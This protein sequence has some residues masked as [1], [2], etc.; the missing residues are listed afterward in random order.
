VLGKAV[1]VVP[2]IIPSSGPRLDRTR[3]ASLAPVANRRIVC[4]VLDA[5]LEVGVVDAAVLAPPEVADE[6]A[7]C[8]GDEGPPGLNVHHLQ[9]KGRSGRRD[10]LLAAAEFV[11]GAPCILQRADCLLGE[12]L[13]P[14]VDLLHEESPD[15][16]L[17]VEHPRREVERLRLVTRTIRPDSGLDFTSTPGVAGVCLLAAGGLQQARDIDRS[18][19]L[20][21]A[22][23]AVQMT[24]N[25]ANV[26]VRVVRALRHFAGDALDLLDMNSSMLDKL[27]S[28]AT[29]RDSGG[30]YFEGRI[31]IHPTAQV[32]SST[33]VGPVI[34]GADARITDS[35]IGPH[36]SIGERVRVDG[37]EIERSI[38]LS[39]ASIL[40]VGRRLAASVVG[41]EARIFRDFSLPRALR[42][43]AG[44]GD[45]LALC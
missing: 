2:A 41:R 35:Y 27:S 44:A 10:A 43:Q 38:V 29:S 13:S 5:L 11:D 17:L 37:A 21:L 4:H 22:E 26:R 12:P 28:E 8:I 9:P 25:G 3:T 45:E 6:V 36:T 33:I 14:F 30:N 32:T 18:A 19:D 16:W 39:D 31:E 1:I 15:S 23:L 42:L 24:R 40:H 34:V 20:D 7:D